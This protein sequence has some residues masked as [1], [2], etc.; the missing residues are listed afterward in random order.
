MAEILA[1]FETTRKNPAVT[2]DQRPAGFLRVSAAG[3]GDPNS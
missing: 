3:I 1:A 2:G